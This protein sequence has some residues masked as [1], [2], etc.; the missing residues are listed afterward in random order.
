MYVCVYVCVRVCL[1]VCASAYMGR[2]TEKESAQHNLKLAV[3]RN[4]LRGK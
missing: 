2:W 1:C 3:S 4:Y